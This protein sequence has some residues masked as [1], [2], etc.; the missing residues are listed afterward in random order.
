MSRSNRLVAQAVAIGAFLTLSRLTTVA[1]AQTIS[2]VHAATVLD[3]NGKKVGSLQ[4]SQQVYF[5]LDGGNVFLVEVQ[6]N[7]FRRGEGAQLYYVTPDC[8]G[9]PY[10][11]AD[12]PGVDI[13]PS[14][15]LGPPGRTLYRPDPAAAPRTITAMSQDGEDQGCFN[16]SPGLTQMALPLIPVID[17]NTQFTPPF[18]SIES[19]FPAQLCGDCNADGS[20]TANEITRVISNVFKESGGLPPQ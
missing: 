16:I 10:T 14:A 1:D 12:Y 3:A 11:P 7:G 4:R 2:N 18:R 9:T 13:V 17:L 19:S 6:T 5:K 20:V 8:S 15:L